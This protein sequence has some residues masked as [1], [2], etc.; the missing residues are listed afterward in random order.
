MLFESFK[1][2]IITYF[3]RKRTPYPKLDIKRPIQYYIA[4]TAKINISRYFS[5]N[6]PWRDYITNQIGTINILDNATVNVDNFKLQ[7]GIYLY[8]GEKAKLSLG[9][10]YMNVNGRIYCSKS[11][12]IGE[13]VYIGE[14][15][16]IRDT[17]SHSIN[18]TPMIA[19]VKIGNHV[20]ISAGCI[21]LKGVTIG[22]GAV[23][24][25]GSV[26]TK[27][28]PPHSLAV[29]CPAKVIKANINWK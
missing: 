1:T 10:G 8:V 21:I 5:V 3:C 9:S 17:D 28:I 22:D 23:V 6:Y 12:T 26:V 25:A 13:H 18:E 29:G 19:P 11:I 16:S 20:W 4:P 14:D 24:G 7:S 27:D 2:K 15:T